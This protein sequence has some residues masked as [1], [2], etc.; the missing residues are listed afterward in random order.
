MTMALPANVAAEMGLMM[1]WKGQFHGTIAPTTPMGTY[2][3]RA[4]L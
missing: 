1:L 2:S 4:D 3:T